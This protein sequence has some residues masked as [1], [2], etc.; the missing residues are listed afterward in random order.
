MTRTRTWPLEKLDEILNLGETSGAVCECAT[1]VEA[2]NLR[3]ALYRRRA[4]RKAQAVTT[5]LRT[6]TTV[7][8]YNKRPSLVVKAMERT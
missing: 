7:R 2:I 5:I 3:Y 6:G 4:E 8:V 1:A